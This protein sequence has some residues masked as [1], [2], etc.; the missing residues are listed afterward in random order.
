MRATTFFTLTGLVGIGSFLMAPVTAAQ[1]C[2]YHQ[3]HSQNSTIF[4][5]SGNSLPN[6]LGFGAGLFVTGAATAV[7]YQ[8][9]SQKQASGGHLGTDELVL[10]IHPEMLESLDT[11]EDLVS[12]GK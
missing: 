5:G 8:K 11:E 2:G 10:T 7:L 12:S 9:W 1:A 6:I 3:T 4:G